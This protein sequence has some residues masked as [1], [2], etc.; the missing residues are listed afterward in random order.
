MGK[1]LIKL[2]V[3]AVLL[4]GIDRGIGVAM[5]FFSDHAI[6]GYVAHH[7]YMNN[8]MS[9]DVLVFGSSRAVH[10]YDAKMIEDSL[11]LTCYNCGQDGSGII[12]NY[13]EWL[14]IKEHCHPKMI[15]YDLQDSYDL[16]VGEP[17]TKYL[18]WLKPYYNRNGIKDI[19]DDVDKTEKWKMMSMMYRNNSQALQIMADYLH[20]VYKVDSYGFLPMDLQMDTLQI[21]KASGTTTKKLPDVDQLKIHYFE[22]FIESL[23]AT[24]LMVVV[25]P[26]WYGQDVRRFEPILKI[27]QKYDIPFVDY[28]N[29][30]K[31]VHQNVYFY[32]GTHLNRIGAETFTRDF[33]SDISQTVR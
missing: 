33:I 2:S 32:N 1:F 20:P 24:K 16:Y 22:K 28:S 8:E 3:F 18:G 12:L 13:G 19:F 31:Y 27:C 10:H 7:N 30:K 5:A 25:S 29:N 15:V 9:K 14:M 21:R 26:M 17:N 11:G 6:G 4:F 23:G